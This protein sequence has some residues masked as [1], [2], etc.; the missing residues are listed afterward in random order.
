MASTSGGSL[1]PSRENAQPRGNSSSLRPGLSHLQ[2]WRAGGEGTIGLLKRKYGLRRSLFKGTPG[3]NCWV[4]LSI[5]AYNLRRIAVLSLEWGTKQERRQEAEANKVQ[6]SKKPRTVK[7]DATL[8]IFSGNSN[9]AIGWRWCISQLNDS[10]NELL[11]NHDK[12]GPLGE[13]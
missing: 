9:S 2:K 7:D 10:R 13:H 4:A 12:G 3:T 8:E 6:D 1:S 11:K 5:F